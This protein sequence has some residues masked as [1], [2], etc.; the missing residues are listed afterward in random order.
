L[1]AF[2]SK[3]P[4]FKYTIKYPWAG[5]VTVFPSNF[6]AVQRLASA[7]SSAVT[8]TAQAGVVLRARTISS[9]AVQ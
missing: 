5:A 1:I 6:A 7:S 4:D 3:D 2:L 8:E 9:L